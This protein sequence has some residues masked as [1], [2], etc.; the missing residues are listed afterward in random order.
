LINLW[1]QFQRAG[2]AV[3]VAV[4][5]VE[6]VDPVADAV[7]MDAVCRVKDLLLRNVVAAE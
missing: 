7:E 6:D 3:A 1:I 5:V 2:V 4:A